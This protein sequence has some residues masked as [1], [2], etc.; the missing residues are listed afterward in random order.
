MA[1]KYKNKYETLRCFS[2]LCTIAPIFIFTMI[3]FLNGTPS[4]KLCMGMCL[5][6]T[7]VFVLIDIIL[8]HHLRCTI[9]IALLGIHCCLANLIPVLIVMFICTMINEFVF[10]PLCKKYKQKYIINKEIDN[11]NE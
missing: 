11:R 1:Q 9:W 3:A 2:I 7:I 5:T 10:E 4:Q 8:K 6:T